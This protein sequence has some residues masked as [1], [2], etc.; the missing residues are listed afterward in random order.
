MS[1]AVDVT[2]AV[3][4]AD[5]ADRPWRRAW[6]SAACAWG[7]AA[8]AYLLIEFIFLA[9]QRRLRLDELQQVWLR[10][11]T[12]QYVTIATHGYS[13][14]TE[15]PAFFPL[16][17]LMMRVLDP[18]LPG[19]MVAAGLIVSS[20]AC[21]TALALTYR[22]A[23]DLFDAPLARRA[24]VS[25]M[26]FP[27]GFYLVAAYNESTFLALA[28][29]ALYLMRRGQWWWA[30]AIAGLS[31]AARPAGVLL[32]VPFA[33]EYLRQRDW[34]WRR[35]RP[36]VAAVALAPVG[37]A[38]YVG[39]NWL[40]LGDPLR[41]SHA[42]AHWGRTTQAPWT[43]I[44]DALGAW[45][46][47]ASQSGWLHSLA[48]YSPLDLLFVAAILALLGASLY[49]PWRLG[50]PALYLSVFGV[51]EFLLVLMSPLGGPLPLHGDGRYAL[52]I[53]PIFL[54]LARLSAQR[55]VWLTYL[56]IAAPAQAAMLV[57]FFLN[58]WIS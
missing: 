53:V 1:E 22:L 25:L 46:A 43:G 50:S 21:T 56:S 33:V 31:S 28:V 2:A 20:A 55:A 14:V 57:A 3:A 9:G 49:G 44:A 52:E 39:Y 34:Q 7:G 19:D 17:P 51:A 15:N 8:A 37:L 18:V 23:E 11:D 32:A 4:P 48:T 16:Y 38:G 10:W 40:A 29:A 26:A 47:R 30:G 5:V 36:D 58:A 13:P 41:F 27:F 12:A 35:I 24:L 54:V 45:Q 6:G 42:Q